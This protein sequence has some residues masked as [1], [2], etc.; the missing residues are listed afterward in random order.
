MM[1]QVNGLQVAYT[2]KGEGPTLVFVHGFPLN[3]E[4]WNHQ[5]EA[6]K[7]SHRV[8]APDLPGFGGSE[9]GQGAASMKAFAE[10]LFT[11]CHELQ[12]GPIVLVGHSM[13]GYIALAFAKAFPTLLSGLVLVDTKAGGDEA[14]VAAGRRETAKKVEAEGFGTVVEAMSPN[15]LSPDNTDQGMAHAVRGF[16]W[17]SSAKGVIDALLGMAERPDE[18]EHIKE[19]RVPTLVVTGADD[20]IVPPSESTA[21]AAAIPGARLVVIPS[22][23]HLVAFEQPGAFDGALRTWLES[24]QP[25][26]TPWPP[27]A[28]AH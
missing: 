8:I 27:L 15:M 18:R 1:S 10:G 4:C 28:P 3:R 25:D 6:F 13:G 20:K 9:P 22:S 21:L 19:I 2:D 5:I 14:K 24:L 26:H 17:S 7:D 12:T 23:G 11:L 16:M